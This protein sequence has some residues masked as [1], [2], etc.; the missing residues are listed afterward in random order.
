LIDEIKTFVIAGAETTAN[1]LTAII[2]YVFQKKSVV[3]RLRE[4]INQVIKSDE[5]ITPENMKKLPYLDCIMT[6]SYRMFN[7][8][9]YTFQRK[10]DENMTV[11]GVP[12]AK[13]TLLDMSWINFLHSPEY[14]ENPLEFIPE[15]WE[16]EETK[17]HQ[18]LV[19]MIFSSGPR[20]CIG[21][22]LALIEIKV[23]M[24]KLMQR[25]ENIIETDQH[26]RAYELPLGLSI[27]NCEAVLVKM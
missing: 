17:K 15:R 19:S 3:E 18:Q 20:S 22:N 27:K 5:N 8:V 13:G 4:E 9:P 16:K 1:M 7:S 2:F 21:K 10:V 12:I 24:I 6:E 11:G 25:Y 14:F 26:Q 23:M